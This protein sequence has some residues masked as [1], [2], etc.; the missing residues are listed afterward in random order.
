MVTITGY[1]VS[2]NK[3]GE[4]FIRLEVQG[5]VMPVRSQKTGKLYLTSKK[6]YIASTYNEQTAE[7][8]IGVSIP[9]EVEK[10]DCDPFEYTIRDTGETITMSHRYEYIEEGAKSKGVIA[11][12]EVQQFQDEPEEITI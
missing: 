9:G 3:H 7:A 12:A 5:G 11:E 2:E 10:V 6:A 8:L 4:E 1:K